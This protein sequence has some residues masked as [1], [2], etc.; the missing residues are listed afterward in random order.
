MQQEIWGF[1]IVLYLFLG[2]LGAGA[3]AFGLLAER[4]LL[5]EVS[6][7]FSKR[8]FFI[9]PYLIGVGILLLLFDLATLNPFKI[10]NL[11]FHPYSMMS[12]GTWV[13]ACF[14]L[15]SIFYS[16]LRGFGWAWILGLLLSVATMGYTGLLLYAVRAFSLWHNAFLP[17]LF[18]LSALSSGLA[19]CLIYE[20]KSK[21]SLPTR[22]KN[23]SLVLA[24]C[25]LAVAGLWLFGASATDAG[26]ASVVAILSGEF[27]LMFWFG[28]VGLGVVVPLLA[29]FGGFRLGR[30][31][32]S[33]LACEC[34]VIAASLCLRAVAVYAAVSVY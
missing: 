11:L 29:S 32:V 34:A 10:L 7:D 18:V 12:L 2:G 23:I 8:A 13:L 25:E 9:T 26:Y 19:L 24:F 3:F 21:A 16:R 28:F 33:V 27:W 31:S 14:W 22:L 5:G 20:L 6:E 17:L 1:M 30:F 4:G 15:F